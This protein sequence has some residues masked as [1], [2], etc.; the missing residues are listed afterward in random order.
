MVWFITLIVTDI[1]LNKSIRGFIYKVVLIIF[2]CLLILRVII[3]LKLFYIFLLPVTIINLYLTFF[4]F[5]NQVEGFDSIIWISFQFLYKNIRLSII[6]IF[7][8]IIRFLRYIRV[9]IKFHRM[10]D[11]FHTFEKFVLKFLSCWKILFS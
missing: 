11:G 1:K 6:K 3:F 8:I 4:N 7:H 9:L 2:M 10:I 5:L